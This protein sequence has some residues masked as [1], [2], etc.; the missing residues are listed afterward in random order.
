MNW[1][2]FWYGS[3][4]GLFPW[5]VI[6]MFMTSS[7]GVNQAPWFVWVILGTYVFMFN[8]FPWTMWNQ[9]N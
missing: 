3:L 1:I 9:Y 8:T 7:P 6:F 2:S 5:F 4:A